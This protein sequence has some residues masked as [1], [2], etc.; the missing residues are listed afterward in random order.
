MARKLVIVDG[1]NLSAVSGLLSFSISAENKLDIYGYLNSI[2]PSG[3][4]GQNNPD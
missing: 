1:A 3:A 4:L 2:K